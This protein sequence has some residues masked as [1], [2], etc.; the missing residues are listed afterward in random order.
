MTKTISTMRE[1]T[2]GPSHFHWQ[3]R[4]LR[5]LLSWE[6]Q[7]WQLTLGQMIEHWESGQPQQ[8]VV[9]NQLMKDYLGCDAGDPRMARKVL[10]VSRKFK[11]FCRSRRIS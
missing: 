11:S 7:Q 5:R 1:A 2:S 4:I 8:D 10:A 3:Q 6:D 9:A